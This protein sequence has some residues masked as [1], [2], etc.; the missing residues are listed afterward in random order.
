VSP[1]RRAWLAVVAF[2][3]DPPGWIPAWA[4]TAAVLW[5]ALR[6]WTA[7][8]ALQVLGVLADMLKVTLAIW[9][10]YKGWRA[11]PDLL[12]SIRRKPKG[13]GE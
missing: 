3:T 5:I 8:N 6:A 4:T 10:G 12:D 2:L 1:S 11:L 9:L 13:V 7:E